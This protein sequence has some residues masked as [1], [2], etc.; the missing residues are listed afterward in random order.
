M[1]HESVYAGGDNFLQPVLLYPYQGGDEGVVGIGS[2]KE[3][4]REYQGNLT[5]DLQPLGEIR[6]PS[7]SLCIQG[8]EE[9]P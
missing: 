2:I 3:E 7:E 6:C 4:S 5:Q 8:H 1:S 9:D